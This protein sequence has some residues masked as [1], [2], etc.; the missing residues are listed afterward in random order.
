MGIMSLIDSHSHFQEEGVGLRLFTC[1]T[2]DMCK[3]LFYD[4]GVVLVAPKG[5]RA[6]GWLVATTSMLEQGGK[7]PL[8]AD[9]ELGGLYYCEANDLTGCSACCA[10]AGSGFPYTS[11]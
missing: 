9:A 10:K 3:G 7:K 4:N 6:K 11:I 1:E 5:A 8:P 2:C